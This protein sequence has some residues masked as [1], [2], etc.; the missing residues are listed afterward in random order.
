MKD[1]IDSRIITAW[2]SVLECEIVVIQ[3][4]LYIIEVLVILAQFHVQEINE[5]LLTAL[6]R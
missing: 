1:F 5:V 6:G 4:P 3:L 2:L